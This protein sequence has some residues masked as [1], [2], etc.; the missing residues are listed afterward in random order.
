MPAR[1]KYCRRQDWG[2]YDP[3]IGRWGVVDEMIEKHYE[4]TGYAY[5][6]N[7][8]IRFID[9]WGLDSTEAAALTQAAEN[10][11]ASVKMDYGC[12]SSQCNRG[13]SKAFEEVT[14]SKELNGK[15]ANQIVDYMESSNDFEPVEVDEVQN[16]AD[17][18]T[19]VIAGKK[20]D[21]NGHVALAVPGEKV[22]STSWGGDVP[23]VMD[24]GYKKRTS[25]QGINYSWS[26]SSSS[27]VSYYKY[28]GGTTYSGGT[29]QEVTVTAKGR[30][31]KSKPITY[32]SLQ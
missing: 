2:G 14:E 28:T 32:I 15:T 4:W 21:K 31:S 26:A 5:V 16:L 25:K 19:V 13:V 30:N 10:A 1:Q 20:E 12:T 29:L 18:G 11:V 8:P 17:D 23:V 24:T 6:Y 9:L 3:A 22:N 27:G 7:N